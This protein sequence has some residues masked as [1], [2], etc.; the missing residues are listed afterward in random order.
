MDPNLEKVCDL[1]FDLACEVN[2]ELHYLY[3]GSMEEHYQSALSSELKRKRFVYH[4]E[5]VIELHYKGFP[6]KEAEADYVILPGGPNKFDKNIVI[7]VKHPVSPGLPKSRL[8][9]FTYLHSGPTNNNP[10]TKKLRY[11]ILLIWPTQNN[12]KISDDERYAE[13]SSPVPEPCMELWKSTNS[14]SRNKFKLLKKW[15]S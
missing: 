6:I 1:I 9:L 7:E 8:Q 12:P 14:T 2:E 10:L 15:G 5:T 3:H 13:L 11:G 4:S